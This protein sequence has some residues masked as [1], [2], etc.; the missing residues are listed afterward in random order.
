M[1][2]LDFGFESVKGK[3]SVS[4]LFKLKLLNLTETETPLWERRHSLNLVNAQSTNTSVR[5]E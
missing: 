3:R 1:W 5:S 4:D 2:F